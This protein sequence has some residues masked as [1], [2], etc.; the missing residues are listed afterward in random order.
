VHLSSCERKV[1]PN[2]TNTRL[3]EVWAPFHIRN[4]L[5]QNGCIEDTKLGTKYGTIKTQLLRK[6][7][8]HNPL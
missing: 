5:L 8:G 7:D 3:K 4:I 2:N 6:A 1:I